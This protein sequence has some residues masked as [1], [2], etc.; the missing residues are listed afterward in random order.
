MNFE[1]AFAEARPIITSMPGCRSLSLSRSIESPSSYLL[2][3]AWEQLADHTIG[4]RKSTRYE[5]WRALLHHFDE[6][7]PLVEHYQAVP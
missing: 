7:F 6:P 4:F 3:V 2:L 1:R 5:E